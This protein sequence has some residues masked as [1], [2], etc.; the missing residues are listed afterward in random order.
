LNSLR[1]FKKTT[2]SIVLRGRWQ[3]GRLF[4]I[5]QTAK[6]PRDYRGGFAVCKY[7]SFLPV[8]RPW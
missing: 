8:H 3:A 4:I 7:F 1:D 5:L 6:P 2:T